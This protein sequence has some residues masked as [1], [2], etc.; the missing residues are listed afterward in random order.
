MNQNTKSWCG[1]WQSVMVDVL[2]GDA[3]PETVQ[4][5]ERHRKGCESCATEFASL[6][7][8]LELTAQRPEAT[9]RVSF[10]D[11]LED[12]L[13]S[14]A[15]RRDLPG[16]GA[17]GTVLRRLPRWSLH[18]AAGLAILAIG[19]LLGR[20]AQPSEE[21]A[22]AERSDPKSGPSAV[23]SRAISYL[24]RSETL[25]LGVVN[26]DPATE[27]PASL[28]APHRN[29]IAQDLLVEASFLK[30]RLSGSD[31]QRLKALVGDL[32][33]I[34]LQLA[35][36][37]ARAD[38]P[39]IEIVRAGVDRNAILFKIDLEQMRRSLGPSR[40]ATVSPGQSI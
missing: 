21:A 23:E 5:F 29:E 24:D 20:G 8:T 18:L 26:F 15:E 12:R 14:A 1:E 28:L 2:F 33:I 35:N 10:M 38:I 31:Q 32:E 34:L 27:D 39:D 7:A 9:P 40:H 19:V 3:D 37:E 22:I 4:A 13:T 30:T 17:S 6:K 36:I 11:G 16:V 25:L